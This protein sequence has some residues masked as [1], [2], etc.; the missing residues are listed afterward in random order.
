VVRKPIG[1]VHN[2]YFIDGNE[3]GHPEPMVVH[4]QK[5]DQATSAA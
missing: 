4:D 2:T 3:V 5:S 1:R